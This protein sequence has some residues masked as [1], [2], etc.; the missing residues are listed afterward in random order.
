VPATPSR[1][2]ITGATG[3][4]ATHLARQLSAQPVTLTLLS[5]SHMSGPFPTTTWDDPALPALLREQSAIIHLA[6]ESIWSRRWTPARK[7]LLLDSRLDLLRR[8]AAP[9][10]DLHHRLTFITASGIA[11]YGTTASRRIPDESA[12]PGQGFLATLCQD[13]EAA[14]NELLPPTVRTVH[15]RIGTTLSPTGV[16]L[17]RMTRFHKFF[18][19][20]FGNPAAGFSWIHITDLV[21]LIANLLTHPELTGPLNATAPTPVS[22][23]DFSR[24][25]AAYLRKP[26]CLPFPSC[27]VRSALGEAADVL[28]HGHY[29]L[30]Q[31]AL[32]SGFTFHF[33]TL[34]SA[35]FDLLPSTSPATT[36][37]V[38]SPS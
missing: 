2:L 10:R 20:T 13:L 28:L 22:F 36:P 6:G 34:S 25:L 4:I 5:R 21:R 38:N 29:V 14:A 8:L 7:R 31:K 27:A 33:P 12:S 15:L 11:W 24:L 23:A 1:I 17:R 9:L 18:G 32:A 3:D 37:P 19:S 35:L 30:P 16:A 26:R